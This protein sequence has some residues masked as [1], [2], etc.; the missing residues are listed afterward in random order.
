MRSWVMW[1]CRRSC[2]EI[3]GASV[4]MMLVKVGSARER[5]S[6]P[7]HKSQQKAIERNVEIGC[8][9]GLFARLPIEQ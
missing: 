1:I 3:G 9:S 4:F 2:W 5:M 8:Q 7:T 6:P